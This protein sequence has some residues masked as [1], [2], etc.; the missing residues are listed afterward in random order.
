MDTSMKFS[1]I[2]ADEC[3]FIFPIISVTLDD[4]TFSRQILNLSG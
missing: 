2:L 4:M 3:L 1:L